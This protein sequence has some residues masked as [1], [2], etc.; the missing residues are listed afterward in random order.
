M[1]KIAVFGAALN[2]P[3]YAHTNI[4]KTLADEF[5]LVLVVPSFMHPF[6]KNMIPFEDRLRMA[7][8]M[9]D[10][11]QK[12]NI[13]LSA[14]ESK[15]PNENNRIYTIDVLNKIKEKFINDD[16]YFV[17]GQDNKDNFEKFYKH[18]EIIKNYKLKTIENIPEIRSTL[19]REELKKKSEKTKALTLPAI[20]KYIEKNNLYND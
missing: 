4:I 12:D 11:T 2:P 9:I 10:S 6:G 7:Q 18:D 3:T 1:K 19:L 15:L 13:S 5:D 8:I 14:I 20:L 16:I 17:M